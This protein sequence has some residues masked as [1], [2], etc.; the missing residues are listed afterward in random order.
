M[1]STVFLLRKTKNL[2]VVITD[3]EGKLENNVFIQS[4]NIIKNS[5]NQSTNEAKINQTKKEK[6]IAYNLNIQSSSIFLRGV[7]QVSWLCCTI[8]KAPLTPAAV[9]Q[10]RESNKR[11]GNFPQRDFEN[12]VA[13]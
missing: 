8:S 10:V 5:V 9:K 2:F 7:S 13:I 11:R 4:R 6:K 1:L 12:K 3:K